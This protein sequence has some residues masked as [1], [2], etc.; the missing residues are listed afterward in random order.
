MPPPPNTPS[1]PTWTPPPNRPSRSPPPPLPLLDPPPPIPP[2]PRGLRPTVSWGGS[3]RPEPRGRPPPGQAPIAP[4]NDFLPDVVMETASC[5]DAMVPCYRA[6][7]SH[8]NSSPLGACACHSCG[9]HRLG[10][11]HRCVKCMRNG[12]GIAH[13]AAVPSYPSKA[14]PTSKQLYLGSWQCR[15]HDLRSF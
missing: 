4:E 3:W 13:D 5:V 8:A 6:W 1:R 15:G 7:P 11:Q 9:P 14:C 2:P 12:H 10:E